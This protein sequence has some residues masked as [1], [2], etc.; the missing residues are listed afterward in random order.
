VDKAIKKYQFSCLCILLVIATIVSFEQVRN[1]DFINFDDQVYIT[2]NQYVRSG[3]TLDS[4]IWAF[5]D[6]SRLFWHPLT[7]LS[8][9]LD[10][11]LFGLD[12]GRH[13]TVNLLLHLANTLLLFNVLTQMTK[14]PWRSFFVAGA[15]AL[16]PMHVESVAWVAER[17][18]VL[19]TLFWMLTMTAYLR[20]VKRLVLSRYLFTLMLFIL[21][22][23][24]KPM[25]VTLPFVLLL[26]DYWP[27]ERMRI[28]KQQVDYAATN[29]IEQKPIGY[30]L[31]EKVPFLIFSVVFGIITFTD[32]NKYGVLSMIENLSPSKQIG[33]AIVSYVVYI[34][35][36]IWPSRL[37]I[38]YLHQGNSLSM[39]KVALSGALL[40]LISL[41]VYTAR[42]RKYLT[43]GWLW[44]LG[45]LL[46]VIGFIQTGGQAW[47]DRY[48]YIPLI[49]LF[50]IVAW[51]ANEL[52]A[53]LRYRE[54]ASAALACSVLLICAICTR[55]QV[56]YWRNNTTIFERAIKVTKNNYVAYC[57]LAEL[58]LQEGKTQQAIEYFTEALRAKPDFIGALN[59]LGYAL[60]R[61]GKF[62]EAEGYYS[63][64]L[65]I[66]PEFIEARN[67]LA[68]ALAHQGKFDEA[69]MHWTEM[70][71]FA[72]RNPAAH[73]NIAMIL[74]RQGKLDEA[75]K[76]LNEALRIDPN[77]IKAREDLKL[78]LSTK[79]RSEGGF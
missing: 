73:T 49:G 30:L 60:A 74:T 7:W 20:Y 48:S 28:T 26:L 23:M 4:I 39:V 78:A 76:H 37:A 31:L 72:P 42:K 59:N 34:Y 52:L 19:S 25:L 77:N 65:Q 11:Q 71:K 45:V 1:F 8:H 10:C 2:N 54:I 62:A 22:L 69:I 55:I 14:A 32:K 21:G 13:H 41:F 75:V 51:G 35:K 12:A 63:K 18:D 3:L 9:M 66:K 58:F 15:F 53:K 38:L 64:A 17:K 36:M 6:S 47:A 67:N 27:L 5:T 40:L 33:N 70:I 24:A 16:H 79:G 56:Q 43:V 44:Y 50:I 68:Q 61:Q 46:P 29:N 57:S